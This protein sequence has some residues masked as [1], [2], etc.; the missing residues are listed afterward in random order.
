MNAAD[1]IRAR[2]QQLSPTALSVHDDSNAHR[3]HAEAKNGGHF[4]LRIVSDHFT[5]MTPLA[6]H[7]LVYQTVGCLPDLRIHA[8]AIAALT[9]GEAADAN[10]RKESSP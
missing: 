1:F 5:G 8:L 3:G 4:R 6:R 9:V 7:R 10:P 2:L